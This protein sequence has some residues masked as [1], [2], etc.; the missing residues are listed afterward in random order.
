MAKYSKFIHNHKRNGNDWVNA[1]KRAQ[2]VDEESETI[3]YNN[4]DIKLLLDLLA[5]CSGIEHSLRILVLF[6][7][8]M[9]SSF[10]PGDLKFCKEYYHTYIPV[11]EVNVSTRSSGVKEDTILKKIVYDISIEFADAVI[12]AELLNNVDDIIGIYTVEIY[13]R[14]PRSS[15]HMAA[16]IISIKNDIL[17]NTVDQRCMHS[18]RLYDLDPE[19]RYNFHIARLVHYI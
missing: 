11:N 14:T 13:P 15:I 8:N 3:Y 18:T 17:P 19:Q 10:S 6:D 1:S 12:M 16:K 9:K 4:R 2:F 5:T 7:S